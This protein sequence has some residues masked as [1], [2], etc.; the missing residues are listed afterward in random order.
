MRP[1]LALLSLFVIILLGCRPSTPEKGSDAIS[2]MTRLGQQGQ[3][4]DAIRVALDWMKKHPEETSHNWAFYDQIAVVYLMKASKDT[5]HKEEWIQQ[6]VSY[7]DKALSVHQT[8]DVD[9]E[10]Y[11]VGRGVE[12][13]GDLSS[14]NSCFYF[15]RAVKVFEQEVSFIQGDSYTAYGKTIRWNPSGK[16]MKS[17]LKERRQNSPKRAANNKCRLQGPITPDESGNRKLTHY[18]ISAPA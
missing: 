17:L 10:L 13:A 16:K 7:Y 5:A 14:T 15:G 2:L 4:D 18:S 6:A 9:V 12:T 11:E 3:Y 1:Q 8:N